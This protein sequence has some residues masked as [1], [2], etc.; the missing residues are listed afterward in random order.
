MGGLRRATG[1][2]SCT[3][4]EAEVR[5]ITKFRNIFEV[6][7][8]RFATSG[9]ASL[10]VCVEEAAAQGSNERPEDTDVFEPR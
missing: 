1:A 10:R 3:H 9:Q 6:F 7:Q 4:Y 8:N 5:P 2:A